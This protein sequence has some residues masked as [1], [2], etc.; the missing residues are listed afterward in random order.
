MWHNEKEVK[1]RKKKQTTK[2]ALKSCIPTK[3]KMSCTHTRKKK[4]VIE[5]GR[6][7]ERVKKETENEYKKDMKSYF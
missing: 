4:G 5:R 7:R 6:E 1:E 2:H 3:Y